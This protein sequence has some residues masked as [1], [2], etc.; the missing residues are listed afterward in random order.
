[1]GDRARADTN[2]GL[3]AVDDVRL[4]FRQTRDSRRRS[5]TAGEVIQSSPIQSRAEGVKNTIAMRAFRTERVA[6]SVSLMLAVTPEPV[7]VLAFVVVLSDAYAV[8]K[9][10]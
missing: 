9:T 8:L 7:P 6:R 2:A 3:G 4:A 1:V 10:K 5:E